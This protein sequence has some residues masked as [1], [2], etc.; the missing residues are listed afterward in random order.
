MAD[1]AEVASQ[2]AFTCSE[3]TI[4]TLEQQKLIIFVKRSVLEARLVLY[5]PLKA[6]QTS[7]LLFTQ[8]EVW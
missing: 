5:T 6:L 4:K 2:P 8:G 1:C 7:H 3:L